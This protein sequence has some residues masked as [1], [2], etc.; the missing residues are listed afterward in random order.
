M[1]VA[2]SLQLHHKSTEGNANR[3]F[4]VRYYYESYPFF[5][6]CCVSAEVTYVT[7]YVLQHA[8]TMIDGA[9]FVNVITYILY[10]CIP[11]CIT[12]QIVNIFQLLSSCNAVAVNDAKKKNKSE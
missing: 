12:K 2:S 5:G 8:T 9:I 3:F 6:Y 10:A 1:Y 7:L 4:L 11:G